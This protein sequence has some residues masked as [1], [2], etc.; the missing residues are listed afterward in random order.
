M[1]SHID[2][3]KLD[4]LSGQVS[5]LKNDDDDL[6]KTGS[7]QVLQI[8]RILNYST[9]TTT[10]FLFTDAIIFVNVNVNFISCIALEK[11]LL[12]YKDTNKLVY[13]LSRKLKIGIEI[14]V[15]IF[16]IQKL[17]YFSSNMIFIRSSLHKISDCKLYLNLYSFYSL[18][19]FHERNLQY[20]SVK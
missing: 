2:K 10:A 14:L 4:L 1:A 19:F 7:F 9:T 5:E 16:L 15:Q 3:K 18:S 20:N 17:I 13:C 12:L 11:S 6:F 8:F